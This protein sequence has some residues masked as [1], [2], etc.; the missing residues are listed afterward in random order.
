MV[1]ALEIDVNHLFFWE[2]FALEG[3]PLAI[4]RV[5]LLTLV[6]GLVCTLFF[7]LGARR[8]AI[9][10]KGFQNITENA[11]LF[12]RNNIAVD[13]IGPKEGLKYADYLT[14]LFFFIFF[15]NLLEIVPGI[16]F[17]ITA[18]MGVPAFLALVTWIIFNF[19]GFKKQGALHYLKDT[20]FPPGVPWP[21]YILLTP[22]EF[23]SVFLIRPFTLA[24]R[25]FGNMFAGHTLL[26]I[27][28]LFTADF[29]AASISLVAWPVTLVVS[30]V[31][32]LFELL[33]ISLQAY[34]FT[35]LTAFYISE[36][37]HGHGQA[38]SEIST[39]HE[40]QHETEPATA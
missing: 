20:L 37:V 19:I 38:D 18:R 34:I 31:L 39:I 1:L 13:V 17:P 9:I 26:T 8:A 21:I 3:T 15:S 32:I 27:F 35:M 10:P 12:V 28:F 4:N 30:S 14:S 16:N 5:V 7:V 25:L 36:A 40:T 29:F 6:A 22:I 11:Y 23:F 33:V 24:V 2:S